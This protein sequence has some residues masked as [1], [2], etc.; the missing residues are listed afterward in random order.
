MGL[1]P[2]YIHN[3]TFLH[4]ELHEVPVRPFLHP[5]EVPLDG[6]MT[7][8]TNFGLSGWQNDA[9][10]HFSP[11]YITCKLAEGMLCPIIQAINE[12]VKQCWS[13]YW[14]CGHTIMNSSSAGLRATCHNLLGHF[15]S[16]S[17]LSTSLVLSDLVESWMLRNNHFLNF[18]GL[19]F[20]LKGRCSDNHFGFILN[21]IWLQAV[22]ASTDRENKE[23]RIYCYKALICKSPF[24]GIHTFPCTCI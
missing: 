9:R 19:D 16:P 22:P 2:P 23:T 1:F 15:Y 3:F 18:Y 17:S 14:L 10:N 8:A 13:Q 12:D 4:V 6:S 5:V 7:P 21:I 11:F 20:L 24:K